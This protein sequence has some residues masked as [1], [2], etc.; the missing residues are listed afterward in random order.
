MALCIEHRSSREY[1]HGERSSSQRYRRRAA[2]GSF[3]GRSS[4]STTRL[5]AW[6]GKRSPASRRE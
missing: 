3:S 4:R 2:R 1:H 6:R 5:Q